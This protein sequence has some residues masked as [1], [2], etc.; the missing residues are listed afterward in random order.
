MR[1]QTRTEYDARM[2]LELLAD[3]PQIAGGRLQ[4]LPTEATISALDISHSPNVFDL[5]QVPEIPAEMLGKSR[6]AWTT[7]PP[8]ASSMRTSSA[9]LA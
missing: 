7:Q 5:H 9:S 8:S 1:W 2:V 3:A 4:P 6:M